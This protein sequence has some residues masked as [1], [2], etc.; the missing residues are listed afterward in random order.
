LD[1][2]PGNKSWTYF[3]AKINKFM[4]ALIPPAAIGT[5]KNMYEQQDINQPMM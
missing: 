3:F 5:G 2:R 1:T 4:P